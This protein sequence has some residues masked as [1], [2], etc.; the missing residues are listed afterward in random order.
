MT[1]PAESTRLIVGK[2]LCMVELTVLKGPRI[3]MKLSRTVFQI[4]KVSYK[5]NGC[6]TMGK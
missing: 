4:I 5:V 2:A 6:L 1:L 3:S